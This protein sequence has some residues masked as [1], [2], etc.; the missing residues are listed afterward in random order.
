MISLSFMFYFIFSK[1]QSLVDTT[2]TMKCQSV[3]NMWFIFTHSSR[4][5][6]SL[7]N[8]AGKVKYAGALQIPVFGDIAK[9]VGIGWVLWGVVFTSFSSPV[10]TLGFL[11]VRWS[12]CQ[13][14]I[15]CHEL[16]VLPML[17]SRTTGVSNRPSKS[18]LCSFPKPQ[19]GIL[20]ESLL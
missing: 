20:L 7:E 16:S 17:H 2:G 13:H 6:S 5:S 8:W 1:T 15:L 12:R 3:W 18:W 19:A 14:D 11:P 4:N 9:Q 10:W